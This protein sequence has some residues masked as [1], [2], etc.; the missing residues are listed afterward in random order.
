M[1]SGECKLWY[2]SKRRTWQGSSAVTPR[3]IGARRNSKHQ[4][5]KG[6]HRLRGARPE[7]FDTR[8]HAWIEIVTQ[9]CLLGLGLPHW[10]RPRCAAVLR[11]HVA[12]RALSHAS[13]RHQS[14]IYVARPHSRSFYSALSANL[15]LV[16]SRRRRERGRSGYYVQVCCNPPG[17]RPSRNPPGALPTREG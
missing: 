14:V 3:A 8:G 7:C 4:Q 5:E 1:A 11:N 9:T 6:S 12:T 10:A 16:P 17:A 13:A 15:C 2:R